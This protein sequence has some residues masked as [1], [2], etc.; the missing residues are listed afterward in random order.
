MKRH[1]IENVA[2]VYLK[3][4][5]NKE[6]CVYQIKISRSRFSFRIAISEK[7]ES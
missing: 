2:P 1:K 4:K 7:N 3:V 6:L 5:L